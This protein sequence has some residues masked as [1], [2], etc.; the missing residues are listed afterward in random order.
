QYQA[1][2]GIKQTH[3]SMQLVFN[4]LEDFHYSLLESNVSY[5]A[6]KT[7]LLKLHLQGKN[8]AVENGRQVNFNIQLEEDLPALITTMQLSNQVSETIKKR[9]QEKLAN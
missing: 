4:V 8:P 1:N 2:Q 6:D 3:Q 5:G 9:I 7:L